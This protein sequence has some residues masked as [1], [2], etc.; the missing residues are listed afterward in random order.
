[1][2]PQQYARPA[3]VTAQVWKSPVWICATFVLVNP[4]EV[5]TGTGVDRSVSELSPT[6]PLVLSPQQ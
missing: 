2:A 5:F 4:V 1:L 6:C 3:D